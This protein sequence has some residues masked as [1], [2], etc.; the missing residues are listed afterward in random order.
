[1]AQGLSQFT[2]VALVFEVKSGVAEL[3]MTTKEGGA[4]SGNVAAGVEI[5]VKLLDGSI[6]TLKTVREAATKPYV[7]NDAIMTMVPYALGLDAETVGKLVAS[8]IEAVRI[9]TSQGPWDWK[10]NK[11]TQKSVARAAT[12]VATQVS[13]SASPSPAGA[14]AT[15]PI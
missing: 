5:P 1:M 6:L 9:P 3:T 7:S 2:A 12:C 14:P 4:V 11:G 13:A 15:P 8:P 10:P